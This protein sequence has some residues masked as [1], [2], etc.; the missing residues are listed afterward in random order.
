MPRAIILLM[1][2][3][4]IGASHDAD[5]FQDQGA[6]TLGHIDQH[7]QQGLADNEARQGPLNIPHLVKLGLSHALLASSG[8]RLSSHPDSDELDGSFGY[9]VEQ[10]FGKDTPSGHWEIAGVPAKFEWGYFGDKTPSFPPELVDAFIKE[11]KLPGVLANKA[12]SGTVVINDYGDEHIQTG[13]PILYTSGDSVFQI[14]AHEEHFGLERLYEI[15]TIARRLVDPYRIGRVI[16]RP[17]VGSDG[18]YQRTPN[19]RDYSTPPPA[20]TLLDKLIEAGRD[21]IALGKIADIFAHRG[22]SQTIKGVSNDDLFSKTLTA[23]DTAPDGSLLFTN[24]VDFDS[25]YGHR[26][27]VAGYAKALEDF[28]ARLPEFIAKLKDD[29]LC[30]ITADHGCDPTFPGSDH[31]REHIPVIAF[32]PKQAKDFIGRRECFADI[33][34]TIAKHLKINPLNCGVAFW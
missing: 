21:V 30:I 20:P 23:M 12:A 17:F 9:A 4:G 2:S 6:N 33:G 31:T 28:D 29:D 16:A 7:C 26:R 34:Q 24:F 19:R 15:C 27:N 18:D 13:K 10:S 25:H 14:A 8:V 3:F 1:D 32:G 5:K 11:S 22:I